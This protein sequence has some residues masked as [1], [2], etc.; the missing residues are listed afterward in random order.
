MFSILEVTYSHFHHILF[1][2]SKTLSSVRTQGNGNKVL[3][4]ERRNVEKFV[5]TFKNDHIQHSSKTLKQHTL[6]F[7]TSFELHV[8]IHARNIY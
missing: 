3:L 5:G 6:T 7:I 2:R 8:S 1:I 4:F